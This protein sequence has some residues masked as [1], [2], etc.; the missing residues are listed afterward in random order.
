MGVEVCGGTD[1]FLDGGVDRF[2]GGGCDR[3][4]SDAN[5]KR[6]PAEGR[7]VQVEVRT[8][9]G[10]SSRRTFLLTGSEVSGCRRR[11]AAPAVLGAL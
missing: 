1:Q 10:P 2:L 6:I 11:R 7:W 9:P 4:G 3:R 5:Q 8:G